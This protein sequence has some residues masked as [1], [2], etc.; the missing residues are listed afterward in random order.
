MQ[1]ILINFINNNRKEIIKKIE[2]IN[3]SY[4]NRYFKIIIPNIYI[5]VDK[6]KKIIKIWYL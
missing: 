4:K 1:H 3:F 5:L 2:F 6:R